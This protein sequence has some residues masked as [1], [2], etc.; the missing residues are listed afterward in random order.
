MSLDISNILRDWPYQPG[1]IAVRRIRGEDGRDKI[2]M[3]IDLGLLQMETSGR[4]DGERPR[5]HESLLDFYELQLANHR[6]TQGSDKGFELDSQACESLRAEG[7]MYYHRYLAEFILEEF[8]AA[9]RD[10]ARNLRLLDLCSTYAADE[11]D[12]QALEQY[13]PYIIM[14]NARAK[15]NVAI[16]EDQL[17]VALKA[18][19][20]GID[21]IQE[22]LSR[23]G[24]E[25]P[26]EP[27]NE[28]A[29]LEALAREIENKS[30]VDPVEKL[31]HEL[32]IAVREERY[33]EAARLRDRLKQTNL[34][35]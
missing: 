29:V 12:R 32:A 18:V 27:L 16:K 13:R 11:T 4:P 20:K 9:V 10:T 22:H 3:R 33:E 1:Q 30:P 25:T 14:M 31:K 15:A 34:G 24:Q 35:L 26:G 8:P 5:G 28:L 23:A 6:S 7:V 19:R 17:R 2:Q 21:D